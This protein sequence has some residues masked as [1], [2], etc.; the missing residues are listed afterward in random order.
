LDAA[1]SFDPACAVVVVVFASEA[2]RPALAARDEDI[3]QPSPSESLLVLASSS[4]SSGRATMNVD[5]RSLT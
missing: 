5:G 4:S 1:P 3:R 2:F